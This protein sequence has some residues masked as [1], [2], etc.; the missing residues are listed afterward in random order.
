MNVYW[1][2]N[3][4][5][6]FVWQANFKFVF[7]PVLAEP[8]VPG[9]FCGQAWQSSAILAQSRC[10]CQDRIKLSALLWFHLS[11]QMLILHRHWDPIV[12]VNILYFFSALLSLFADFFG[13]R[14]RAHESESIKFRTVSFDVK[15]KQGMILT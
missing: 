9:N 13:A 3:T 14:G 8:A 4:A 11:L 2:H 1:L 10:S 6:E 12:F 7:S 15:S 5:Y